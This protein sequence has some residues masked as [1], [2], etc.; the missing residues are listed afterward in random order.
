MRLPVLP[1]ALAVLALAADPAAAWGSK[2]YYS[3]DNGSSSSYTAK[4]GTSSNSA[5]TAPAGTTT[6]RK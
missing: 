4:S 1:A 2:C 6:V 5:T 3:Y